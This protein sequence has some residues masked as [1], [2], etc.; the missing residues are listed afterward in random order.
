M[1]N[2]ENESKTICNDLKN[3]EEK[4]SSVTIEAINKGIK[5]VKRKKTPKSQRNKSVMD[6]ITDNK[7]LKMCKQ[8]RTRNARVLTQIMADKPK[9]T[10]NKPRNSPRI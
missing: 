7:Y 3:A 8:K 5:N 6:E 10:N 2:W 1:Q 4:A 9:G